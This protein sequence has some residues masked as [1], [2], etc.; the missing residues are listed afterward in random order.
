MCRC[1]EQLAG[2]I[3]VLLPMQRTARASSHLLPELVE[4]EDGAF[5]GRCGVDELAQ[6]DGHGARLRAEG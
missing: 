1:V 5:G 3:P 4:D 2:K 6:C